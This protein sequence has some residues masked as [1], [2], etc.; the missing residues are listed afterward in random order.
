MG[1]ATKG[2]IMDNQ[3]AGFERFV[4][5]D[6]RTRALRARIDNGPASHRAV[7][8]AIRSQTLIPRRPGGELNTTP[9]QPI[10]P[11][12]EGFLKPQRVPYGTI[13]PRSWY[14]EVLDTKNRWITAREQPKNKGEAM[15]F[16]SRFPGAF[17]V[18]TQRGQH[19]VVVP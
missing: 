14:L 8:Q 5:L 18:V 3:R 4:T 11:S 9:L 15:A 13:Q 6:G 12:R 17:R 7:E 1:L 2:K 10:N 19:W 16:A